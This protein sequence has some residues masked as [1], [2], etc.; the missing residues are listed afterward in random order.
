MSEQFKT[1]VWVSSFTWKERLSHHI[2]FFESG[3]SQKS[4]KNT[5]KTTLEKLNIQG[6][7]LAMDKKI[8]LIF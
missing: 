7:N 2:I 3:R 1:T 6:S 5:D 4:W 8:L